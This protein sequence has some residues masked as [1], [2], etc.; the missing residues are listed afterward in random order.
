MAQ[1]R[2]TESSQL[3]VDQVRPFVERF[4]QQLSGVQL[5]K[6]KDGKTDEATIDMLAELIVELMVYLAD[7]T[8]WTVTNEAGNQSVTEES[9]ASTLGSVVPE[10]F[11]Q[12][13]GVSVQ[14]PGVSSQSLTKMMSEEISKSINSS[15]HRSPDKKSRFRFQTHRLTDMLKHASS[16]IT[17][18]MGNVNL[19]HITKCANVTVVEAVVDDDESS[20]SELIMAQSRTTESSQLRVDQV[21]PFVERFFQQLS[22]VQLQKLK[23][24]KI[25]EAT[26]DMLAELL[27]ELMVY[28][29]DTTV[30][31][32]TN[33]AGNQSVTEE[34]VASTLGSVVPEAFAQALGVSV[35]DPGVSSQS[36]T[37]MMSEEISKS[38]N[39]ST[40]RSQD[41]KS[42]F[43]FQTHRLTDMLKHASS[44]ITS[45]MGNVNLCL[46]KKCANVTVVE[47]VVDDN[48]SSN[49]ELIMAPSRTTKSSQLRVDQVR[50]IVER[51]FQQLSGVQLQK[52][53]DEKTDE[54]TKDMLAELIV[55]L[56]VYLIDSTMT[57]VAE[58]QPVTEE[59]V[60]STLG[61]VVPEAFAQA[62][63]VSVQDPGVS[64]QS[65]TKMMSE[66]I[67]ESIN[68]SIYRSRDKKSR[69]RFQTHRL[70]DM[71][72]HASSMITS[73][74][75]SV[76]LC[77]KTTC[78]DLKVVD[79]VDDNSVS[80]NLTSAQEES[81]KLSLYS[82]PV[83]ILEG[84]EDRATP[85]PA[86]ALEPAA[87]PVPA[88]ALSVP[89]TGAEPVLHVTPDRDLQTEKNKLTVR[90]LVEK[91]VTRIYKKA[92]V[93][94]KLNDPNIIIDL[95][96]KKIWAEVQGGDFDI[97]PEAFKSLDKTVFKDL[98]EFWGCAELV[99][100]SLYKEQ[101]EI[102]HIVCTF[103]RHLMTPQRKGFV[104]VVTS[105]FIHLGSGV[106]VHKN[107]WPAVGV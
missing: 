63:G 77:R 85:A 73:F 41:K 107:R 52:L 16:M 59:S 32:V 65:L 29:A 35:Q 4:F 54:A 103:T 82:L 86:P 71:V 1:S 20:N 42:R 56:M 89:E 72:K 46:I 83:Q 7:T 104:S 34:S 14:D 90:I 43:R 21:R 33:E 45:F 25:D 79:T 31:T 18:F 75:G 70:T 8:V 40:H 98:V 6:L 30:W 80:F 81:T 17:S 91:L 13:L 48:E 22:G 47:A 102:D 88:P 106:F 53:K 39:S 84:S 95:L 69:F 23:D 19:C 78:A 87:A 74:M 100:V 3:R 26:K 11:A 50:P 12:A 67:S 27:M 10:A 93:N 24:G 61:S 51:F 68:S 37:K 96:S 94:I 57:N 9:V 44:M 105:S 49:S 97:T 76:S 64:S 60:A 58:N 62:L 55:E 15:T 92:K 66:E 2:S 38:I 28:L 36:L 101:P 99:L 5:Q